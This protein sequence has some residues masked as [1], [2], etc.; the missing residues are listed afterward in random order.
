MQHVN[1]LFQRALHAD[2]SDSYTLYRYAQFLEKC[3]MEE[4]AEEV[5]R[6]TGRA[7][8]CTHGRCT[9]TAGVDVPPVT[10]SGPEQRFVFA[11]VRR[12]PHG[13]RSAP[14]RRAIPATRFGDLA[15]VYTVKILCDIPADAAPTVVTVTWIY[16]RPPEDTARVLRCPAH[17]H[18]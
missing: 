3:T 4:E 5:R 18:P 11:G 12:V 13:A 17:A 1:L 8:S 16:H 6:C 15:K 10:R 2:S 14:R 9:H 7:H